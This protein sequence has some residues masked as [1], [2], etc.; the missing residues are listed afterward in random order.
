MTQADKGISQEQLQRI[1]EIEQAMHAQ[2]VQRRTLQSQLGEVENAL[3]ELGADAYRIIGTIMVKADPAALKEELSERKETLST[4]LQSAERQENQL[5]QE[6][7][8]IQRDVL[9]E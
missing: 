4:R 2:A 5:R 1:Q 7:Q 3:K 6:L 9:G 8:R